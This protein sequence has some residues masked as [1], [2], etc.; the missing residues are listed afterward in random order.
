MKPKPIDLE[1]LMSNNLSN[2]EAQQEEDIIGTLSDIDEEA[3]LGKTSKQI[4][5]K[6]EE[7]WECNVDKTVENRVIHQNDFTMDHP[8]CQVGIPE[9]AQKRSVSLI[10]RIHMRMVDLD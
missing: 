9:C 5:P 3:L 7:F 1:T 6:V 10:G 8:F 2:L 4:S